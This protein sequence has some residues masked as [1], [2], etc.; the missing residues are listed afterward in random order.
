MAWE[1]DIAPRIMSR[2]IKQD[3]RLRAFKRQTGHLTFSLKENRGKKNQDTCC[4]TINSIANK[5]SLQMKKMLLWKKLSIRKMSLCPVIQG[6]PLTSVKDRTSSLSWFGGV[7]PIT[8]SL[9]YIFV[10]RVLK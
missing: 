1:M 8:A 2:I 9:L 3:L 6:N 7:C 10:K 5:S 4:C